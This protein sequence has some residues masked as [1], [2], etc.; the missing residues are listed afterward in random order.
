MVAADV[1]G[2]APSLVVGCDR[3][4]LQDS[5]DV[6]FVE[7]GL[8][9]PLRRLAAYEPLRARAG[10]D[11]GGLDA[12]DPPHVSRRR[13]GDADDRD[14]LLGGEA[15]HGRAPLQ[16]IVGH[17]PYLRTPGGLPRDDVAGDVLGELLDEERLGDDLL[18]RLLEELREARHVDALL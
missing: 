3:D 5:L 10:V 1:E 13:G 11:A 15:R 14:H 16:W 2:A 9:Q 12:D 18:D 8:E 7:A 4:Q 6:R 17:D